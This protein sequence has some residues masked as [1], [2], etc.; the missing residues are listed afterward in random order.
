MSTEET[1]TENL[2][3]KPKPPI[4]DIRINDTN[5]DDLSVDKVKKLV[6]ANPIPVGKCTNKSNIT[7]LKSSLWNKILQQGRLIITYD[8]DKFVASPDMATF[9]NSRENEYSRISK[10]I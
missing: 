10:A 6:M 8:T 4:P 5:F 2:A 9:E 3:E 1:A 7:L